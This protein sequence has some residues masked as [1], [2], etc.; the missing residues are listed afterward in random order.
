LLTKLARARFLAALT[1][2]VTPNWL[3]K[4]SQAVGERS[5]YIAS[6]RNADVRR[7]TKEVRLA[8]VEVCGF[9]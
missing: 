9:L 2:S 5:K 1:R 4:L 7:N 3:E 8:H 6:G